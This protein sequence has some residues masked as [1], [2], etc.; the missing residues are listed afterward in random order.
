MSEQSKFVACNL[1]SG[2]GEAESSSWNCSAV[3]SLKIAAQKQ[4]CEDFVR[5]KL[6]C[7]LCTLIKS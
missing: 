2:N 5:S 4:G 3:A 6:N 1:G 7:D